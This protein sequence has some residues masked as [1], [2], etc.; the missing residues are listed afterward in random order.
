[1]SYM[2]AV[3]ISLCVHFTLNS[4]LSQPITFRKTHS[5]LFRAGHLSVV[6]INDGYVT[7]SSVLDS[8][9]GANIMCINQI[10]LYGNIIWSKYYGDIHIQYYPGWCGSLGMLP[11]STFYCGGSKNYSPGTSKAV[12]FRFDK[13]GDTLFTREF[14]GPVPGFDVAYTARAAPDGGFVLA[15]TTNTLGSGRHDFFIV[16]TD[17]SGNLVWQRP[18]GYWSNEDAMDMEI[19]S[20]GD[21]YVSGQS[22]SFWE[23]GV[24]QIQPLVA[25][26]N[27]EG[28][29]LWAKNFNT[30]TDFYN[31]GSN[32]YLGFYDDENVYVFAG[33]KS[34]NHGFTKMPVLFKIDSSGSIIWERDYDI[35]NLFYGWGSAFIRLESG[36]FVSSGGG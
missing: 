12:L 6:E 25:K 30:L 4:L 23:L 11:D 9:S 33:R 5:T 28:Q 31:R 24:G 3:F 35:S 27:A 18:F 13:T 10:D 16:K 1:M 7:C 26:F 19:S 21:I 36:D 34:Q 17:S 29:L 15:G 32:A 8:I 22:E 2:K 14:G 20:N